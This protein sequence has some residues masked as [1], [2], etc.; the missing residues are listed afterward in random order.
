[1]SAQ[2]DPYIFRLELDEGRT[3]HEFQLSLCYKEG[4]GKDKVR[5]APLLHLLL[6]RFVSFL[7]LALTDKLRYGHADLTLGTHGQD[8]DE[9]NFEENRVSFQR[10]VDDADVV[11]DERLVVC[12]HER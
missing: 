12:Y 1:M 11:N 6:F 10:F 5:G 2:E 3:V 4:W 8:A 9:Y 7:C